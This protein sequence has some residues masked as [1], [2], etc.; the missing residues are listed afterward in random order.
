MSAAGGERELDRLQ[1]A[2]R[3]HHEYAIDS[4]GRSPSQLLIQHADLADLLESLLFAEDTSA[5]PTRNAEARRVGDFE[6]GAEIGRGGMGIVYRATQRSLARPVALKVLHPVLGLDRRARARFAREA[7]LAAGLNHRGIT[8]VIAAVAGDEPAFY[9]MELV[10]GVSL[11]RILGQLRKSGPARNATGR[12]FEATARKLLPPAPAA[13]LRESAARAPGPDPVWHPN[14]LR[15]VLRLTIQIADALHYAHERGVV[16]RDVKPA[17]VLL[18][19]DGTTALTDFGLARQCAQSALT[20]TG[21]CLG[22]PYYSAPEQMDG[23]HRAVDHR[24]DVFS[25]GVL[26]FELLTWRRP[27]EAQTPFDVRHAVMTEEPPQP[28]RINR[29]I[30]RDVTAIVLRALE[31]NPDARYASAAAMRTDL[32]AALAGTPVAAR[33]LPSAVL[34]WRSCRGNRVAWAFIGISLIACMALGALLRRLT[35]LERRIERDLAFLAEDRLG[36]AE[37][38]VACTIC[39]WRLVSA[40]TGGRIR[41]SGAIAAQSFAEFRVA[42]DPN[43]LFELLTSPNERPLALVGRRNHGHAGRLDDA[44]HFAGAN[45]ARTHFTIAAN[46]ER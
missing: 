17:N 38:Q 21:D 13:G 46:E 1:R 20:A 7:R 39:F 12:Q 34:L 27:F 41:L 35:D 44:T 3:V 14:H 23:R 22:T 5:E 6:I 16:H 18:R 8:R 37:S 11:D 4:R 25:L 45:R 30:P 2:L 26:L 31:K 43:V 10:D 19:R 9:A 32:R 29:A 40:D 28:H 42:G 15:L 36:A 24:A 33:P